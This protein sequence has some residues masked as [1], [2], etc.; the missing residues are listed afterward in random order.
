MSQASSLA[1]WK[2]TP[3]QFSQHDVWVKCPEVVG[4]VGGGF[5]ADTPMAQTTRGKYLLDIRSLDLDLACSTGKKEL[6]KEGSDHQL[7]VAH[8]ESGQRECDPP[9]PD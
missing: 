4:L 9:L 2:G 1:N 6:A 5:D 3:C 8:S 7:I